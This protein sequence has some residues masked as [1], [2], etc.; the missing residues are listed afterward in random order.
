MLGGPLAPR[1]PG[2]RGGDHVFGFFTKILRAAKRAGPWR[3]AAA[4]ALAAGAIALGLAL[5]HP[6]SLAEAAHAAARGAQVPEELVLALAYADTRGRAEAMPTRAGGRGWVRLYEGGGPRGV[7]AGAS[8]LGVDVKNVLAEPARGLAA[9]A[10]LLAAAPDAPPRLRRADPAAWEGP[11]R[12][13]FA[14]PDPVAAGLYADGVLRLWRYGFRSVDERGEPFGVAPA[15]GEA[16]PLAPAAG[17]APAGLVGSRLAT[18]VGASPASHRPPREP[19]PRRVTHLI[20][21]TTELPF[22]STVAFFR[23]PRTPVGSHYGLR[24][25]DGLALQFVDE[26]EVAFHDACFN[27]ASIGLEH[28]AVSAA[29]RAWFNVELYRASAALAADVIAR[30]GIAF[31]REHVLGHGEAPDCSDHTDPGP[32]WDWDLYMRYVREALDARPPAPP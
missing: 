10:R 18:Y 17:A 22:A 8:A 7:A 16:P 27:E 6:P 3:L 4:G 25:Q 2:R 24:A 5:R 21:H 20:V 32:D 31:D 11:L 30:H 13:F 14:A 26:A 28:E 29:G 19:G 12:H 15:G 23:A 9:A 1:A